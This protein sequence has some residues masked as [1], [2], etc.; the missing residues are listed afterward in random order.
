ML[1]RYGQTKFMI[2]QILLDIT[3]SKD[4]PWKCVIL[5]YFNPIGAHPSGRIGEDPS[6]IPNNLMPFIAQ[7]CV[8]RR[9]FLTVFG[10]DF[11]TPDG[12]C[13]RDYIHVQDLALGSVE[14]NCRRFFRTLCRIFSLRMQQTQTHIRDS[15]KMSNETTRHERAWGGIVFCA[16]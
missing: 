11:D 5:R 10:D 12:T 14:D 16:R 7:V 6:G 15:E 2:E 8:G 13:Q 1:R 9:E 4:S 3:K